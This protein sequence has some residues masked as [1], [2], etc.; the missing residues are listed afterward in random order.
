MDYENPSRTYRGRLIEKVYMKVQHML[1][2]TYV[3]YLSA[4]ETRKNE[5]YFLNN[6][7]F[8]EV[9]RDMADN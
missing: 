3:I 9:L 1:L 5:T 8:E 4:K 7:L 6:D 2:H